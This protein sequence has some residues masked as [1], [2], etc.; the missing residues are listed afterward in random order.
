MGARSNG[1]L[2]SASRYGGDEI[3]ADCKRI[4]V[5]HDAQNRCVSVAPRRF[6]DQQ[7]DLSLRFDDR[8]WLRSSHGEDL[9]AALLA[10]PAVARVS[11]HRSELLLELDD[12]T[13]A[14]LERRLAG[15]R[16]AGVET[17]DLLA[18]DRYEVSLVGPNLNKAL[19]LG[20]FRNVALGQAMVCSLRSAGATVRCRSLVADIGRRICEAMAG[21]LK[22]HPGEDPQ[23]TGLTEDRFVEMCS[24]A[25]R[26]SR[27]PRVASPGQG[28][29]VHEERVSGDP[30]DEIMAAWLRGDEGERE[31][32]QKMR[33]WTL[34][35]HERTLDRLGV[36]ID[37]YDFESDDVPLALDLVDEGLRGDLFE[38]EET[39][40]VV[41]RTGRSEYA[42]M[43]LLNEEGRP[44]ECARVLGVCYR[45]VRDLEPGVVF[46]EVL[47]DEWRPAQ[48]VV[49]DL[50]AELLP[51][52]AEKAY[53]WLY[54][55]LVT[56]GGQKMGSSTGEVIWID[57]FL[58][59][60]VASPSVTALSRAG[61]GKVSREELADIVARATL[62]CSPMPQLLPLD[63]ERLL[64]ER[65]GPGWIIAEA[66][67]RAQDTDEEPG[68]EGP[69]R[70]AII[71]SQQYRRVLQLTLERRDPVVLA[72]Y[73]LRL[74][75]AFL[76]APRPG[77]AARPMLQRVLSSLGFMVTAPEALHR[78]VQPS[79]APVA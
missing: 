60:L 33:K 54:Y 43:V 38:R 34:T 1:R 29:N 55:G 58:D 67:A 56:T 3:L 39:G 36:R 27:G 17:S 45:L 41:H 11:R 76:A 12:D 37:E 18:G 63:V 31:L 72:N 52:H 9:A 73:L 66:W 32:W 25:F 13:L 79:L 5:T 70:T 7:A 49:A 8:A 21:Y 26:S 19:H 48:T 23:S 62:L 10:H 51:S 57:D 77:P 14:L 71:Q 46:L 20:H 4:L 28:P 59:D 15:G 22:A 65:S 2:G 64:Q 30:A 69:A 47:G 74:S 40:A 35:G 44:T 75:E 42:T 53:E 16:S 78:T 50:I 61:Q 68:A 6:E 24:R